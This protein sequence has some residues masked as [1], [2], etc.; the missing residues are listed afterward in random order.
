MEIIKKTIKRAMTTGTTE[1][2][3]G[4]CRVIIPNT[5]VTYHMKILLKTKANNI[6]FFDPNPDFN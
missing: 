1:N 3:T 2:C 5:G 6:G 4:N